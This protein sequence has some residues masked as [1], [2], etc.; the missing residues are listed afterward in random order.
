MKNKNS[1]K[2]N[3]FFLYLKKIIFIFCLLIICSGCIRLKVKRNINLAESKLKD[4][5]SLNAKKYSSENYE[6]AEKLL[7]AA[8]NNFQNKIYTNAEDMAGRSSEFSDIAINESLIKLCDEGKSA[9]IKA[10][11]VLN[12]N[13]FFQHNP[14]FLNDIQFKMKSA[15]DFANNN[16]YRQAI[17]LY[18]Q[19]CDSINKILDRY[20]NEMFK[21]KEYA[22]NGINDLNKKH[23]STYLPLE[24][25][26]IQKAF[27]EAEKSFKETENYDQ[28]I[29]DFQNVSRMCI[30]M[31]DK[32]S[33]ANAKKSIDEIDMLFKQ[34]DNFNLNKETQHAVTKYKE[35][36]RE[37][38]IL[39][40]ENKFPD[41]IFRSRKLIIRLQDM[42]EILSKE[43]KAEQ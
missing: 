2:P 31:E 29:E 4:A 13:G 38:R 32:F 22:K 17:L 25:E 6:R 3:M 43:E 7:N 34:I 40:L 27:D 5:H 11:Q 41:V 36:M 12:K 24:F 18:K 15:Q 20:S 10:I 42:I 26:N 33:E 1:E 21:W 8:K 35:E 16:D 30:E 9:A 39:F 19:L 14:N 23:Y 37:I 28:A